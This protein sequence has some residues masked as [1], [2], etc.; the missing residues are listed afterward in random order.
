MPFRS[1]EVAAPA[2]NRSSGTRPS[3]SPMRQ[4]L[5]DNS[6]TCDKD[7]PVEAMSALCKC[8]EDESWL[9]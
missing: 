5:P 3:V 7:G 8:K 1:E 9:S 2:S 6:G 4:N